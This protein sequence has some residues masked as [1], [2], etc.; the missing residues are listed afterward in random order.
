MTELDPSQRNQVGTLITAM[1]NANRLKRG[2]QQ[3][4]NVIQP[5]FFNIGSVTLAVSRQV[6]LHVGPAQLATC[7]QQ[8]GDTICNNDSCNSIRLA[9][10]SQQRGAA[11]RAAGKEMQ[12]IED[13]TKISIAGTQKETVNKTKRKTNYSISNDNEVVTLFH[14]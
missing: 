8:S 11:G 10:L 3:H 7:V 4:V 5:V 1:A 14:N 9:K 2:H 13:V 12:R 6:T